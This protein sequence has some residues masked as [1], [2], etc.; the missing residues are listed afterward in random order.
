MYPLRQCQSPDKLL[1]DDRAERVPTMVPTSQWNIRSGRQEM[2]V[3]DRG[4][5][6]IEC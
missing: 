4:N 6:A 5:W 3:S 2:L 1:C